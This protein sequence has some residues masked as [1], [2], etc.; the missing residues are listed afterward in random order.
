MGYRLTSFFPIPLLS[1]YVE[2]FINKKDIY[3]YGR[4]TERGQYRYG[5]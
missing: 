2:I 3:F 4:I 1:M 5:V